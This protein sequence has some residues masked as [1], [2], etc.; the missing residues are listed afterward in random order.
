MAPGWLL[1]SDDGGSDASTC[2]CTSSTSGDE[3]LWTAADGG[4]GAGEWR[5]LWGL[6]L[7]CAGTAVVLAAEVNLDHAAGRCAERPLAPG[8]I[9]NVNEATWQLS[10]HP[11]LL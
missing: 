6:A 10:S 2:T 5:L 3:W 8:G 4:G 9:V 1:V 7:A 11:P